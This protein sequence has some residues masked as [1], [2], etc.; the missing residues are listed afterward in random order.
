M[1]RLDLE[2]KP[3]ATPIAKGPYSALF[4]WEKETDTAKQDL[5]KKQGVQKKIMRTNALGEAFRLLAEGV[6]ATQGSTITPR[7]VNPGILSAVNEYG[8]NETEYMQKMAGID[9]KK[10]ALAS[11]DLKYKLGTEAA[12][13]DRAFKEQEAEKD[14]AAQA[15]KELNNFIKEQEL[16][17]KQYRLRGMENEAEGARK[18]RQMA[19]DAALGIERDRK[20]AQFERGLDLIP[21]Q[22]LT[23]GIDILTPPQKGDKGSMQFITPDTHQTIYLTPGLINYISTQLSTGKSQ[24]DQT[25]PRVLRDIMA[26]KNPQPEALAKAFTDNWDFIRDNIFAP[27]PD[28]AAQIGL[29]P[30]EAPPP[31]QSASSAPTQQ[32]KD[33]GSVTLDDESQVQLQMR[34]TEILDT[35]PSDM[36]DKAINEKIK[37]IADLKYTTLTTAGLPVTKNEAL[38]TAM[39]DVGEWRDEQRKQNSGK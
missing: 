20:K 21:G 37:K 24:Y 27:V 30:G 1:A 31:S 15:E 11:E 26:N 19:T 2:E 12:K 39:S 32:V 8:K 14:R 33:D 28:L 4:D 22:G 23:T 7:N 38:K 17:E 35:N 25:I 34:I 9:T 16:L 18:I 6:G 10:L 13:A 3:P 29:K 5:E 36:S